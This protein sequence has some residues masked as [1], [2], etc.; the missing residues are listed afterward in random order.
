MGGKEP[1]RIVVQVE[2]AHCE[3]SFKCLLCPIHCMYIKASI[4]NTYNITNVRSDALN[5]HYDALIKWA[6]NHSMGGLIKKLS[7]LIIRCSPM[8]GLTFGEPLKFDG[9][10]IHS[11]QLNS[12]LTWDFPVLDSRLLGPKGSFKIIYIHHHSFRHR[13]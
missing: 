4:F 3:K 1:N 12:S 10:Y 2:I 9:L 7:M 13:R 11:P 5:D 8:W 6:G